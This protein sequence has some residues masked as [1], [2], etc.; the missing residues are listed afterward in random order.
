ME[1]FCTLA[2]FMY[3]TDTKKS[4]TKKDTRFKPGHTLATGRPK[5]SKNK[6]TVI[7]EAIENNMVERVEKD[8]ISILEKTINMAK[9]G[10]TTCIKILM[11]RLWPTSK[12]D[13]K[14]KKDMSKIIINV[15]TLPEKSSTGITINA[16]PLE[17]QV[18]DTETVSEAN[19]EAAGDDFTSTEE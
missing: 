4:T 5:G 1:L 17:E 19:G 9:A 13:Q 11:D 18:S 15:S 6:A 7:K 10:D 8:A 12:A 16:E 3:M 14:D 2:V